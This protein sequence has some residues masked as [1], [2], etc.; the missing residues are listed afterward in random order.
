[1]STVAVTVYLSERALRHVQAL[2]YRQYKEGH[3]ASPKL[4]SAIRA[5]I[6]GEADRVDAQGYP[7]AHCREEHGAPYCMARGVGL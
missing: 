7:C 5:L 6:N 4:A 3:T 1:M 2:A